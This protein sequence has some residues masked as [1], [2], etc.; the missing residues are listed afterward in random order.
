[1]SAS[2]PLA[3]IHKE[4]IALTPQG[5][6]TANVRQVLNFCNLTGFVLVSLENKDTVLS[7]Y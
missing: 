3:V 1:M 4:A 7:R 5:A 6:I 2:G